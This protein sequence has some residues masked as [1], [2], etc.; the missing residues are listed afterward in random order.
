VTTDREIARWRLRTQRL[1]AP[2]ARGAAEVVASLLGVQAEN[3]SQ[4]AWA[5]ACRTTDPRADDLASLLAS[6]A[7][8]RTHVLRPTW[9]YVSAD[10]LVWLTELTAPRVLRAVDQLL[11]KQHGY[12]DAEFDRAAVDVLDALGDRHLTRPEV[13]AGLRERGRHLDGQGLMLLLA[14]LELCLHVCGGAPSDGVHTYAAVA[15]RV[16][17]PRHLDRDEA[18]A[19]LAL[20][21]FTSHGP[22]TERDLA[23]WA[24]LTLTD[25]RAGLAAVADRLA[26]FE[27]DGR[28]YW[29]APDAELPP[30]QA[31]RGH[32]LQILDEMYRGYQDSRMVLDADGLAP[33]GRE[34]GLGM[35]LVDGQLVAAMK[36]TVSDTRVDFDLAPLRPLTTEDH[37]ALE[38]AASRY[39][40]YLGRAARLRVG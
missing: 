20:R 25:V 30:T 1:V 29:H 19:E 4:S 12:D 39:G 15:T 10:D 3:P 11:V 36:R 24:T 33:G 18:L 34:L 2:H 6:G 16:R 9:H 5:V 37:E 35:A 40:D 8:L 22:A 17:A 28:T 23:Y 32:L 7:V 14:H 26:S 31:P 27:H 38:D 13:D 21:Y